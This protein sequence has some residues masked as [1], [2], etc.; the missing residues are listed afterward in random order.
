MRTLLKAPRSTTELAQLLE[1]SPGGVSQH[2][3][4]LSAATVVQRR[5][6]GRVVL[7][8]RTALGDALV[9]GTVA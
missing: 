4:A 5:R 6:A 1:L 9:S 8:G 3:S 2:L 7:Y